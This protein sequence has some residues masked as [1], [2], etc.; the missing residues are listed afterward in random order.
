[1]NRIL[2][3]Q[4][5]DEVYLARGIL[6]NLGRITPEDGRDRRRHLVERVSPRGCGNPGA[7]RLP[8]PSTVREP[9]AGFGIMP[10]Q[11]Y[12]EPVRTHWRPR[13]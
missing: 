7:S 12:N 13:H 1:M 10:G 2:N 3:A 8:Q 6:S 4:E 5:Q 11:W 9:W